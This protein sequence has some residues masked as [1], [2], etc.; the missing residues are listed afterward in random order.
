MGVYGG[1][2]REFNVH[3][4]ASLPELVPTKEKTSRPSLHELVSKTETKNPKQKTKTK[5]NEKSKTSA[6][7]QHN[8]KIIKGKIACILSKSTDID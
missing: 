1:K 6:N 2:Q 5:E 4:H 7:Q 3:S 8:P